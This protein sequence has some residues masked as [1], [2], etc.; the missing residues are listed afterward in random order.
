MPRAAAYATART[1][2]TSADVEVRVWQAVSDEALYISYR[3][4]GGTWTTDNTP[5]DMAELSASG[6]FRQSPITTVSV[7]VS[8]PVPE[9]PPFDD[10][11]NTLAV[12]SPL[13]LGATIDAM[14]DYEGDADAFA[15]EATAGSWYRIAIGGDLALAVGGDL[16]LADRNVNLNLH[17]PD[18]VWIESF[19]GAAGRFAAAAT[20]RHYFTIYSFAHPALPGS[21]WTGPYTL[22]VT[23]VDPPGPP[24]LTLALSNDADGALLM[25]ARFAPD[26]TPY[27]GAAIIFASGAQLSYTLTAAPAAGAWADLTAQHSLAVAHGLVTTAH[28]FVGSSGEVGYRDYDCVADDAAS[29]AERTVYE[30]RERE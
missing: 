10:H 15:F 29:T 11:G 28:F 27:A 5:L 9:P 3:P 19:F 1:I 2:K 21:P 23:P 25:A 14:I 6:R 26:A 16:A 17:G 24:P 7:P 12:A 30:C 22:T 18:G 4:A 20:G 8:V 13:A